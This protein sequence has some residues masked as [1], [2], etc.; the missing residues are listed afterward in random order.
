M[1]EPTVTP[2]AALSETSAIP[3]APA[4]LGVL[5]LA[6][7]AMPVL[8]MTLLSVPMA[9]ILPGVY[10]KDL[11]IPLATLGVVAAAARV[12]DAVTDPIEG[13]LIDR[14]RAAGRHP[15]WYIV[16]GALLA[17]FG[18]WQLFVPPATAG[19]WHF[20]IWSF[21]FYIGW[22]LFEIP[23]A[24]WGG[25]LAP[26]YAQRTRLYSARTFALYIGMMSFFALPVL[27]GGGSIG[28]PEL[29]V[30]ALCAV[31]LMLLGL[32]LNLQ[33]VRNPITRIETVAPFSFTRFMREL[34]ANRPLLQ[35]LVAFVL[36]GL[37]FGMWSGLLFLVLATH[38]GLGQ[39]VAQ[40]FVVATPAGIVG[41]LLWG[42]LGTR[43]GKTRAWA[44]SMG[45]SGL[46][47]AAMAF[48]KPGPDAMTSVSILMLGI[49][50]ASSG[51]L[52][53]PLAIAADVADY[54][55]WK[56]GQDVAGSSF[57]VLAFAAKAVAGVGAGAAL[58]VAGMFGFDPAAAV[59]SVEGVFGIKL[60]FGW[61][62]A[63]ITLA[64][65]PFILTNPISERR[66]AALRRRLERRLQ[67]A[68]S[69]SVV[70]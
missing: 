26:G 34:A 54:G 40:L 8:P 2:S 27:M 5:R 23:H 67:A 16:P 29:R 41:V 63:L 64:A 37:G 44:L 35:L 31:P 6:A 17:L 25:Y 52:V 3:A 56:F 59:Q 33:F 62:P 65:L 1:A 49:Y 22:T 42:F 30:A 15:G 68:A 7:Y 21:V 43:L 14:W 13:V 48:I 36:A 10:A 46:L 61:I 18:A 47:M 70:A 20:A 69:R 45:L 24:S 57:A 12:F 60:A 32:W 28:L 51:Q 53:L 58:W 55:Q 4:P 66:H 19:I 50:L 9:T 38:L 39:S 11:A